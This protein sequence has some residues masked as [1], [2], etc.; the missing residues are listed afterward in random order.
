MNYDR[1]PQLD[2]LAAEY[3]LGTMHG[4]A[5]RRFERV[6]RD[7]PAARAATDAW[8]HRLHLL[9]NVPSRL[10][11]S[12]DLFARIEQRIGQSNRSPNRSPKPA[13]TSPAERG[14]TRA[15]RA[16]R[17]SWLRPS[18]GFALGVVLTWS[19]LD[20]LRPVRYETLTTRPAQ[21]AGQ[22]QTLRLLFAPQTTLEQINEALQAVD[23]GIVA[24]PTGLGVLTVR[25]PEGQSIERSLTK[26]RANPAV[27]LAEPVIGQE[28]TR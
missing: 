17:W 4:Q 6:M 10:E 11:P 12:P 20:A 25:V 19:A 27:R 3:V 2:R 15:S 13:S 22:G 14:A 16:S 23:A 1:C 28:G 18:L 8:T 9:S 7:S 5:R 26:L 24:G 21:T